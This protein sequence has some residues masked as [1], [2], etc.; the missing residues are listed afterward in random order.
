M[1]KN[2]QKR[3]WR[4]KYLRSVKRWGEEEWVKEYKKEK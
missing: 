4:C 1:E 2:M 3:R